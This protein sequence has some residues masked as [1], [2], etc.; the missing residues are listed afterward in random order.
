[1]R[2]LLVMIGLFSPIIVC[3]E[4]LAQAADIA[5]RQVHLRS[6][7]ASCAACHGT[8]GNSSGITPNISNIY[9]PYF[10]SQMLAFKSGERAATVMH[11]H[12]K[13]LTTQEI[14]DLAEYFSKQS[15]QP[16]HAI[17]NQHLS[18]SYSN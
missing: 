8:N 1:M 16:V 11:H 10:V 6:L 7:A 12:A 5:T 15:R 18:E 2:L 17:A 4:G 13:G 9:K 3:A 14:E